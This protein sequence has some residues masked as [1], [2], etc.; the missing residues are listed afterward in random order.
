MVFNSQLEGLMAD[1]AGWSWILPAE[2]CAQL[3]LGRGARGLEGL[4]YGF[5]WDQRKLL[6]SKE[7]LR[8]DSWEGVVTE[9]GKRIYDDEIIEQSIQGQFFDIGR[10]C[11]FRG[12]TENFKK[13]KSSVISLYQLF[14][15][16][17]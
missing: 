6:S 15:L 9:R 3:D 1:S 2:A 16:L 13:N 5:S 4:S 8:V 7:A 14:F 17:W 12:N 10:S 11:F